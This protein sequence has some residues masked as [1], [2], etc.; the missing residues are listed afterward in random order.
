LHRITV[1]LDDQAYVA[2]NRWIAGRAPSIGP[3]YVQAGEVVAA[4]I[5]LATAY[6]DV[7]AAVAGQIC[8]T[9]SGRRGEEQSPASG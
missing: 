3:P 9:R 8:R 7:S 1:D 2:L 4:M 6:S 5:A